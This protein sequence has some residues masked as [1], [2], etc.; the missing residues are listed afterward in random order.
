L[1]RSYTFILR[2][3]L[4]TIPTMLA[5]ATLVFFLLNIV[6]GDEITALYGQDYTAAQLEAI[7]VSFGLNLP[8]YTRYLEFLER[9]VT[10]NLGYSLSQNTNVATL[11][12]YRLPVT[13]TLTIFTMIIAICIAVPVGVISAVRRNS[14]TDT[15][16]SVLAMLGLSV[17]GFYLGIV[18]ILVFSVWNRILPSGGFVPFFQN[19]IDSIYHMILPATTLGLIL[20]A[21]IM[22]MTRSSLLDT[23]SQEFILVLRAKGLSERAILFRH[24]LRNSLINVTTA[25]GLQVAVLLGGSLVIEEVFVLPGMGSLLLLG[26][27]DRDFVIVTDVV[28]TLW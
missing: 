20:V 27:E 6:P 7:R 24:A 17:P 3:I 23:L 14:K 28:L 8:I 10:G 9:L 19:P 12:E 16:L 18:A 22:R 13:L 5:V 1:A 4:V 21:Y 2:R 11:L 26:V 25:I 15:G